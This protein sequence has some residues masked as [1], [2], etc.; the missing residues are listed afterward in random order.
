MTGAETLARDWACGNG[1]SQGPPSKSCPC[2]QVPDGD[3]ANLDGARL[4][5]RH[6]VPDRRRRARLARR[7]AV[8]PGA[9]Y[10]ADPATPDATGILLGMADGRTARTQAAA[11]WALAAT[12]NTVRTVRRAV[13]AAADVVV[14][15]PEHDRV[16]LKRDRAGGEAVRAAALPV[17]GTGEPDPLEA[18]LLEPG[19]HPQPVGLPAAPGPYGGAPSGAQLRAVADHP[20]HTGVGDVPEHPAD[21]HQV[22][23]DQVRV[24]AGQRGVASTTAG[25]RPASAARRR[26]TAALRGP[27][28]PAARSRHRA[29]GGWTA[30]RSGRRPGRRTG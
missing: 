20:L 10:R 25:V 30:G 18:T 16:P 12:R 5:S 28:R 13:R 26:A 4:P 1:I 2:S 6:A 14:V 3:H 29:A 21:E 23:R 19:A 11:S 17:L 22:G 24:L 8:P 7:P 9:D 15:E 27:A